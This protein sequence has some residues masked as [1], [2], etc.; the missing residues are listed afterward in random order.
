MWRYKKIILLTA[1]LFPL[2]FIFKSLFLPGHAVWGD[3]PYFYSENL[4]NLYHVPLL[5]DFRN[6]NF[7]ADQS[8]VLWLFL[9]TFIF[10]LLNHFLSIDNDI[11]IRIVF[12]FP[13][14]TFGLLGSWLFIGRF[15]KKIFPRFL[16]TFLYIFN[17]YFLTL[18]DGGQV[19]VVLGYG[20]FPLIIYFFLNYL[21]SG[22]TKNFLLSLGSLFLISNTDLR[23]TILVVFFIL[24]FFILKRFFNQDV[25]IKES[26]KRGLLLL[27][28]LFFVN[29]FW[30]LPFL[31]GMNRNLSNPS[32]LTVNLSK[33]ITFTDALLLYQPHF[34]LNEF[35]K[36]A[37]VPFYFYFI[38]PILIAGLFV[39]KQIE[40]KNFLLIILYLLFAFLSKGANFPLGQVYSFFSKNSLLGIAFRDSTKFFIPLILVAGCL[41]SLSLEK[42]S[43]FIKNK[44]LCPLVFFGIYI[45]LLFLIYPA[46]LGQLSGVLGSQKDDD[47]LK[48]YQQLRKDNG[49]FRTLWFPEH[50]SLAFFDWEK[51]ALSAN[52]LYLERPFASM[53]EG[54]YDLFYFLHSDRL[55]QWL[56]LSGIKY[57]FFPESERKKIWTPQDR[58]ERTQ[59]LN[60]VS[61]NSA[62]EKL[63]W[64]T[65]FPSYQVKDNMPHIFGQEKI[66]V[67]LGGENIYQN[68]IKLPGFDLN[69]Q[70]TIFL[71]DGAV[72]P[73]DLNF[74]NPQN[75]ILILGNK[76]L[77]DLILTF[78]KDQMTS[79]LKANFSQ[80]G[81]RKSSDYL[82]WKYELFKGGVFTK[83]F[84]FGKGIAFS[85]IKNEIIKFNLDVSRNDQYLL[86]IRH[87][88][89]LTSAGVKVTLLNQENSFKSTNNSSFSLVLLGPF[90]LNKG[91][92]DI[93]ITNLGGFSALNTIAL[94]PVNNWDKAKQESLSL[95]NRLNSVWINDNL[96]WLKLPPMLPKNSEEINY[97]IIDPTEYNLELNPKINWI[98]FTD[99][100]HPG[101]RLDF[102]SDVKPLPF[103]EMVNGFYIKEDLKKKTGVMEAKLI[104][105][106]REK[107]S[108]GIVIS[109]LSLG[110]II[111]VTN[112]VSLRRWI[113][114]KK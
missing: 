85:S 108:K 13:A 109:L 66:L 55:N 68:L 65:S 100:Y 82:N 76:G 47:F 26:L 9:P 16:G 25:S 8:D 84:D 80:W 15:T 92:V 56:R 99:R 17:T 19:G 110:L 106:P 53:I 32:D 78:F 7:G 33:Q 38:F 42:I 39:P 11:L 41:L 1:L 12:Y 71:E 60:F 77:N 28:C 87:L 63:N 75:S 37:P 69:K 70:G 96:D 88:E 20:L 67:V 90:K 113:K 24:A 50:P 59:F 93:Q 52:L 61:T 48:I 49:F 97:K 2:L 45:Y 30:L 44:T 46:I 14:I 105:T 5:W 54:E 101:W 102:E 51:S 86:A 58:I 34:P 83:D 114:L 3:A 89:S 27:S 21:E 95:E 40:R 4:K 62:F 91:K 74:L 79:P 31:D 94:I 10:G 104:F 107:V 111:I 98:V 35:G 23:I 57:I 103:F 112:I 29:A 81:L 72:N 22:K 18:V 73:K 43:S 64:Q 36:L 6:D